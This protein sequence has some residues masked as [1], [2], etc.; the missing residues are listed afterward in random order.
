M[1]KTKQIF[2]GIFFLIVFGLIG[3]WIYGG[4]FPSNPTCF[5][6]IR[7]QGETDV[8]CGGPCT[9]C[10]V[11]ALKDLKVNYVK[12]FKAADGIGAVAEIYNPNATWAAANFDYNLTLTDSSGVVAE[13]FSGNSFVYAGD[14]KYIVKPYLKEDPLKIVKGNLTISNFQWV[15]MA[16]LPKPQIDLSNIQ[17]TKDST[18]SVSGKASNR[19]EYDFS[20]ANV[21]A[22]V[23]NSSND[24]LAGSMTT[25]DS[26]PK[27]ESKDFKIS[28]S[29]E[30]NLYEATP[31]L[32]QYFQRTFKLGDSGNDVGLLQSILLEM[33][34]LNRQPTGFFDDITKSA[35]ET[36]Q[37]QFSIPVTGEFDDVTKQVV[38]GLLNSQI[39][40]VS[41]DEKAKMVDSS[42]TKVFIEAIK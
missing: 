8:D 33:G 7:N 29:K 16:Q 39:K 25:L 34:I 1:R 6:G 38:L 3:W 23:Y 26:L 2:Y 5:D 28:F 9:P 41:E 14:L 12:V 30:L 19:S 37:K 20:S 40:P 32:S 17:T 35:L 21:Y 10:E 31:D 24:L 13:N 22:L 11:K 18:L 27:F 36:L 15:P 4:L 42:K